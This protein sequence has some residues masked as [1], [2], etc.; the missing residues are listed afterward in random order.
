MYSSK[1]KLKLQIFI[2]AIITIFLYHC[3]TLC[4]LCDSDWHTPEQ[5]PPPHPSR[6]GGVTASCG[7]DVTLTG[8]IYD[9]RRVNTSTWSFLL[10]PLYN[11]IFSFPS[12]LIT[13]AL[14]SLHPPIVQ[15]YIHPLS[16]A[17][18]RCSCYITL[19]AS[20]S[21]N[22]T[23]SYTRS[24]IF[25]HFLLLPLCPTLLSLAQLLHRNV[26]QRLAGF[27]FKVQAAD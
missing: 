12:I 23:S 6:V 10:F 1:L 15:I 13:N 17:C 14:P 9:W 20:F 7:Q 4:G 26:M 24:L 19:D 2:K 25:M 16:P 3:P 22:H 5:P 27:S 8:H 11:S 21:W 18:P